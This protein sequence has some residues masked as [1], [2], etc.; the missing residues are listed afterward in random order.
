[1]KIGINLVREFH[2]KFGVPVLS[3]PSLISR[4]RSF[5]RYRLMRDEV[6]EYLRAVRSRSL[7]D[8]AKELSDILYTVYGTVLEHGLQDKISQIFA[9]VHSSNMSKTQSRYK[10]IK[11]PE[12]FEP[13]LGQFLKK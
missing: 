12:Y 10:M 1:M 5:F 13:N 7:E 9:E 4:D 2:N 8:V 11:G 6:E 3:T